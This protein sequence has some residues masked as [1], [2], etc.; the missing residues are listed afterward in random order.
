M[1]EFI[2]LLFTVLLPLSVV[3]Q[4]PTYNLEQC[5]QMAKGQNKES[6]ISEENV[7]AAK[8]ARQAAFANFFPKLS[9]NAAYMW[10]Q[11][12][13][14]LAPDALDTRI[15]TIHAGGGV[16]WSPGSAMGTMQTAVSEFATAADAI[17]PGA[18]TLVSNIS[19]NISSKIGGA[20]GQVYGD[21]RDQLTF[22]IQHMF[23]IQAGITQPIFMGGKIRELYRIAKA[24]EEIAKIRTK[25]NDDDIIVEVDEAYWRVISVDEKMKLANEYVG[26]L[27]QLESDVQAMVDEGVATQADLLKV[28]VKLNEAKMQQLQ[29][30]NGLQLC[31]MAL[32]QICGMPLD[33]EY[34]VDSEGLLDIDLTEKEVNMEQVFDN[35]TE[36]K[37]LEQANKIAKSGVKLAAST[38]QPNIVAQANYIA[39]NPNVFNGFQKKFNGFFNVGVVMNV[40]IAHVNDIFLLKAAKH[41]ARTIELKLEESREKVELQT[42][43][44]RDKVAEAGMKLAMAQSNLSNADENLRMAREAFTEGVLSSTELLGAQTAWLNA[45][46][47][48]IDTAIE[49]KICQLYFLKH[50][51]SL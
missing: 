41:K 17:I 10:N 8:A 1:R 18:G 23:V 9:A 38:L 47:Q 34:N 19:N 30:I 11:K 31:K 48:L 22:D 39:S 25:G 45:H 2:K 36:L 35:R 33:A 29:A 16:D 5:R 21:V 51:G 15:G 6:Q 46:S 13:I 28:R 49:V 37:L 44:S 4:T 26:L 14:I 24:N 42:T 50:T 3:A 7:A 27:E 43:Q 32:A 40:P 12:N 20:I